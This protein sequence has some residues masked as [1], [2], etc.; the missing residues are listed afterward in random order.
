VSLLY[1]LQIATPIRLD[2]DSVRYLAIAMG[3][4]DGTG[5]VPDG[6]PSGYPLILAGLDR[7]G[8]ASVHAIVAWNCLFLALSMCALWWMSSDRPVSV[9]LWSIVLTLLSVQLVRT[10]AMP[11]PESTFLAVSLTAVAAMSRISGGISLRNANLLLAALLLTGIALSIRIAA[12]TLLPP[13]LWCMVQMVRASATTRRRRMVISGLIAV[14]LLAMAGC[15]LAMTEHGTLSRYATEGMRELGRRSPARFLSKRVEYTARGM[16]EL[17]TNVPLRQFM[18]AMFYVNGIGLAALVAFVAAFRRMRLEGSTGIFL[19]AYFAVLLLWPYYDPRLWMPILPLLVLGVVTA[20]H[21]MTK[22]RTLR[23]VLT[24]W[25][26]GYAAIGLA[27]LAWTTRLSWSGESF[28][29]LYG[30]NGGLARQGHY[31]PIH[32]NYA[33]QIIKRFDSNSPAW[34]GLDLTP[35][36]VENVP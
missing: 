30:W 19:L 6:F 21:E 32:D 4:A 22:G 18:Q 20:F 7:L 23:L 24:A 36:P 9:R 13:L 15:A 25:V 2:T 31:D 11:H 17:V 16:G 35:V 28:R 5:A 10:V 34:K 29:S 12:V 27:A 3:L 14:T 26:A 33:K 8:L 1:L